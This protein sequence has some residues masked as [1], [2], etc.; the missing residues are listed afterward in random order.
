MGKKFR[1]VEELTGVSL[2]TIQ[3]IKDTMDL[4]EKEIKT[5]KE[6]WPD[7]KVQWDYLHERYGRK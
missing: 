4:P 1:E 3:R 2:G 7:L 6:M 5:V